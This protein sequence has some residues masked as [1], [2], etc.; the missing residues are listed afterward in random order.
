MQAQTIKKYKNSPEV[1][2]VLAQVRREQRTKKKKAE[3]K[4]EIIKPKKQHNFNDIIEASFDNTEY[5]KGQDKL[6]VQY[7]EK[8]LK[9]LTEILEELRTIRRKIK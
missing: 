5:V 4:I 8:E 6:M 2:A 1:R 3:D 9:I 7:R